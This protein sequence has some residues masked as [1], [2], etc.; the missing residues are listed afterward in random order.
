MSIEDRSKKIEEMLQSTLVTIDRVQEYNLKRI[1]KG[2]SCKIKGKDLGDIYINTSNALYMLL[3]DDYLKRKDNP[4]D[5]YLHLPQDIQSDLYKI[6]KYMGESKEWIYLP[7]LMYSPD[8]IYVK[9]LH[10]YNPAFNFKV[11]IPYIVDS[12]TSPIKDET[13]NE[14]KRDLKLLMSVK[15]TV[16][17]GDVLSDESVKGYCQH[18][19][20]IQDIT[21]TVYLTC[22]ISKFPQY[23]EPSLWLVCPICKKPVKRFENTLKSD[24]RTKEVSEVLYHD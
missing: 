21:E 20:P 14:V 11:R 2:K 23:T 9:Y 5:T 18:P 10:Y 13:M 3:G 15:D 22:D 17:F 19:I 16:G 8:K 24:S 7:T 12:N 6:T 1:K 4:V